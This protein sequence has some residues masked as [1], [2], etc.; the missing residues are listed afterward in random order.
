VGQGLQGYD[1]DRYLRI[2]GT[3]RGP[4]KACF[5]GSSE[6]MFVRLY[7]LRFQLGI[8]VG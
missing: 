3:A 6:D 2:K 7:D 4:V 8:L 5:V 1:D